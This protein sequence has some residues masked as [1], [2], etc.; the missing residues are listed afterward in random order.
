MRTSFLNICFNL[1]LTNL[2]GRE[3]KLKAAFAEV[4][5][6]VEWEEI[7]F[8]ATEKRKLERSGSRMSLTRVRMA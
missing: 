6:R 5:W 3:N 7:M 2:P 1:Y 4:N 8:S